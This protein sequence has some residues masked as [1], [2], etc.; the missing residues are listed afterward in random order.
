MKRKYLYCTIILS[1]FLSCGHY[2][3]D[4]IILT[5][6]LSENPKA[7]RIGI[8]VRPDSVFYCQEILGGIGKY[9]CFEKSE[10]QELFSDLKKI[11]LN[12]FI[13]VDENTDF[14][15]GQLL[16]LIYIFE[17]KADTLYFSRNNLSTNQNIVIDRIIE[18][19][20]L[21]FS[22]ISKHEFPNSL[23]HEKLPKPPPPIQ[24]KPF[25]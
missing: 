14:V 9:N 15:D 20:N 3:S 7:K 23:L 18:L 17:E 16:Q 12:N 13:N 19:S 24:S 1:L 6:G 25:H 10:N 2:K 5:Q 4:R 8:E 22:Q 21:K 11:V